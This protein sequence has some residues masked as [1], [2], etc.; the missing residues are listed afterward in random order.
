MSAYVGYFAARFR[1]Q[2]QYRAAAWAGIGTQ[3]FFGM[4]RVMIFDA[5]YRSSI[6]SQP[7]THEETMSYIWLGQ[8]LLMLIP[9]RL[10]F[11]LVHGIR[12][13]NVVYEMARPVSLHRVWLARA[14]ADRFGPA[15]LRCV[16][17]VLFSVVVLRLLG[18]GHLALSAPASGT[19]FALFVFSIAIGTLV[20]A[21]LSVLMTSVMFWTISGDGIMAIGLSAMWLLSGIEIPLLM[22]PEWFQPVLNF[23][24]FRAM[25]DIPF[26]IYVGNI[27]VDGALGAIA[28]QIGWLVALIGAGAW[29]I[30]A[31]MRR[32]VV[33]GG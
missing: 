2:L 16:P 26:R 3:V 8:A 33:Q 14:V 7:M 24:P 17:Q 19:A 28:S 11:E 31:G 32:L 18:L 5:L 4:V 20:S 30:R 29:S 1:T 6:I 9:F 10:D 12:N 13:G 25:I 21:A 22:F 23:L 15:L 27:G